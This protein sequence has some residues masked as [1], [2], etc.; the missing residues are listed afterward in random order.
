MAAT[1]LQAYLDAAHLLRRAGF[2]GAPADVQAVAASGIAASTADLINFDK[3]R[4]D[5]D[6]DA[7]IEKLLETMPERVKGGNLEVPAQAARMWWT[8]RML[9]TTRPLEEKMVLF[10]HNHFTS[11]DTDGLLMTQQN[12]L[13]RRHAL[14]NFRSLA[15]AVSK[16][17]EMLRYLNGNQNYRAHPNENYARELMEL[18]TCGRVGPDGKPNYTEDDVKAAARAFSGWNLRNNEFY[19]NPDQHDDTPKTFMGKTGNFNGNDIVEIL[20]ALPATA[21]YVCRKL[22]R[23]FGYYEPEPAVMAELTRVY[24]ASGYDIKAVVTTIFKSDAF[25]SSKARNSLFKSPVEF[26]VGTIKMAGL[27]NLF[28]PTFDEIIDDRDGEPG[29]RNRRM[30][31]MARLAS[32]TLATR[33]MG[34]DLLAPT[35]VKGWDGGQA[36]INTDTIQA[37]GKFGSTLGDGPAIMAALRGSITGDVTV[38]AAAFDPATIGTGSPKAVVDSVLW[39][40]GPLSLTP[41][42]Y[43]TIVDYASSVSDPQARLSGVFSLVLST[44]EYQMS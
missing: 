1:P 24:Y 9:T 8:Y 29:P 10:W 11:R 37:R 41:A 17:T 20:V 12:Q 43:K 42:A 30:R 2:G 35:T 27:T 26:V 6:D 13:Y 14:G 18:F 21:H 4:Y 44:P 32:L 34:Q 38:K 15:L 19:Y 23:T 28:A 33:A 31:P 16:D 22:F 36:W 5:F 3:T 7:F 25:W 40:M 39:R